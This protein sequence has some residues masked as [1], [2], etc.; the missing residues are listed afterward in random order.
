MNRRGLLGLLAGLV[1]APGAAL[2]ALKAEVRVPRV[3]I[4]K[5]HSCGYSE[6]PQPRTRPKGP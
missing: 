4:W 3:K 6:I 5:G 1:A 2:G